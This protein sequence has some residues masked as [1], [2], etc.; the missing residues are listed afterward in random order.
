MRPVT[1]PPA[2]LLSRLRRQEQVEVLEVEDL[3]VEDLEVED[4]VSLCEITL[5]I[6]CLILNW[7]KCACI[8]PH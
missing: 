7:Q 3:E 6:L 8:V 4:Q 1:A 5:Y 2:H